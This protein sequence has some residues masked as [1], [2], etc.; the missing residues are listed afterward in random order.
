MLSPSSP[1][2]RSIFTANLSMGIKYGVCNHLD[3]LV[4]LICQLSCPTFVNA[5]EL[6]LGYYQELV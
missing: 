6:Q 2:R 1:L 5:L 3:L 4:F